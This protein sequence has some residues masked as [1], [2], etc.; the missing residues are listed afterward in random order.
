[1]RYVAYAVLALGFVLAAIAFFGDSNPGY[2]ASI[3]LI[4]AGAVARMV[5]E[6]LAPNPKDAPAPTLATIED[7]KRWNEEPLG[8][9]WDGH[10]LCSDCGGKK[11]CAAC[12]GAG[13]DACRQR[14]WCAACGG[15][16]QWPSDKTK[17]IY[18]PAAANKRPI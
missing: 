15:A 11:L 18:A 2:F 6:V 16:G 12:D 14:H 1:M 5:L 3:F 13:C 7:R 17:S 10:D 4:F 9:A 8:A